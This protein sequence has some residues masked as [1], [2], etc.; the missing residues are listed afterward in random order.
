MI[1]RMSHLEHPPTPESDSRK[2]TASDVAS[3]AGVSKWTVSRAFTEGA[4]ISPKARERVIQAAKELGYRPNLLARS[5]STRKTH[6]VGLVVDE[7]ANP[8]LLPV[9]DEVTQQ[10]QT[11]GYLAILLNI[12]GI[13]S[14]ISP[15]SLADQFQVDGLL[16][17]GTTLTDGLVELAQDVR[18][19]P[20]VVLYRNS[21][22]PGIQV[23]T[24]DGYAAGQQVA[25]LFLGQHYRRIGY[26][27]GPVSEST[28]LRRLEGFRDALTT[29]DLA[30]EV[31]LDAQHYRR[32][33]GHRAMTQYLDSAPEPLLD[34]LFCENDILAIGAMD[35]LQERGLTGQIAIVGFDD[36]GI[37]SAPAYKLTTYRQPMQAMIAEA[38][39]RLDPLHKAPVKQFISGDLVLRHSHLRRPA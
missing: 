15:L 1:T 26:M 27:A 13:Q 22:H 5:L 36:I 16:F 23:V 3:R 34:A 11:A 17:L 4:S 21:D 35:A 18:H 29:A 10:L 39:R 9:L 14:D 28:Q 33:D 24:T 38:I 25:H 37:A 32:E 20:L 2:A 30:I 12:T 6:L 31:V 7:M 19:I 8:N